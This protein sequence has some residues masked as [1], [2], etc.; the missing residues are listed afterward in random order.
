M[1][2]KYSPLNLWYLPDNLLCPDKSERLEVVF[3]LE[4]KELR[5]YS[6]WEQQEMKAQ[7]INFKCDEDPCPPTVLMLCVSQ[8][9]AAAAQ[10][11][12]NLYLK[13]DETTDIGK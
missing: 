1:L 7:D 3:A 2:Y 5:R 13:Q 11:E 8:T 9:A 4:R 12:L 6:V 10:R